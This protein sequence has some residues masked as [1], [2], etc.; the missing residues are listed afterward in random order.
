M[1]KIS[2]IISGAVAI[3]ALICGSSM[4]AYRLG[5]KQQ[6]QK[7]S[8]YY[9]VDIIRRNEQIED[10][11]IRYHQEN[12]PFDYDHTKPETNYANQS[13]DELAKK[14][15][16]HERNNYLLMKEGYEKKDLPKSVIGTANLLSAA[17]LCEDGTNQTINKVIYLRLMHDSNVKVMVINKD[18]NKREHSNR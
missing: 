16:E 15:Q 14:L 9:Q 3:G 7:P 18:S 8:G 17:S 6:V 12:N 10:V 11:R 4:T 1:N 13:L 2:K 5:A